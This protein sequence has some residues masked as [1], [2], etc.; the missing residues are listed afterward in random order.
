MRPIPGLRCGGGESAGASIEGSTSGPMTY[1]S[2][3]GLLAWRGRTRLALFGRQIVGGRRLRTPCFAGQPRQAR[4][5]CDHRRPHGVRTDGETSSSYDARRR[6]S[7][8]ASAPADAAT[9]RG[10]WPRSPPRR[11][12]RFSWLGGHDRQRRA[13][14]G[15]SDG[16]IHRLFA[17]AGRNFGG[18]RWKPRGC[19]RL[20]AGF[21]RDIRTSSA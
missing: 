13:H 17:E 5:Q 9:E 6:G 8:R 11:A 1:V 16:V 21:V 4:R 7:P 14:S 15:A 10:Y 2:T 18:T 3:R 20:H 19:A 12:F